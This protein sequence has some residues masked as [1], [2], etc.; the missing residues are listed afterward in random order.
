MVY[1]LKT[2]KSKRIK[3]RIILHCI[4]IGEKFSTFTNMKPFKNVREIGQFFFSAIFFF[5][6]CG[7]PNETNKNNEPITGQPD[8]SELTV[9]GVE[10]LAFTDSI[11]LKANQNMRFDNELFRVKAGRNLKLFF[12][13]TGLK[14][15]ASMPHNVVILRKGTDLADFA[16]AARMTKNEDYTPSS[17]DSFMIAHTKLVTGG[18]STEI[19]FALP[20]PGVYDFICSFPGHWGTMQG[21]IVAE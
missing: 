11:R 6:S 19:E 12:T 4:L 10:K 1:P 7:Q 3:P 9:P 15:N 17:L 8:S 2:L 5:I 20:Q 13:N 14:T 16:D 21:K 18:D